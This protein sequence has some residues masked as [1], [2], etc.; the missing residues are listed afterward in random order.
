MHI[1]TIV[2]IV[3][4]LLTYVRKCNLYICY[5]ITFAERAASPAAPKGSNP[6]PRAGYKLGGN[7]YAASGSLHNSLRPARELRPRDDVRLVPPSLGGPGI[8]E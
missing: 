6:N 5:I 2:I 1:T 3:K 8:V 7:L 4:I